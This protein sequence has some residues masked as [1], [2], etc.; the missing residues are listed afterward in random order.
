MALEG[1]TLI[2]APST[3]P[4]AGIFNLPSQFNRKDHAALWAKH[5]AE[6]EARQQREYLQGSNFSAEGWTVWKDKADK[7]CTVATRAGET[8]VLMFRK[9]T[10]QD[11]VNAIYGDVS[12]RRMIQ[13]HDGATIGG[14][15]AGD[16]GM[17]TDQALERSHI[18][19]FDGEVGLNIRFNVDSPTA[20]PD[21]T[22]VTK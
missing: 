3:E 15:A 6:V 4:N 1:I 18:R 16:T 9:R 7:I 5:G 13:E 10:I 20:K 8:Y 14:N 19:D 2:K 22:A 21:V 11:N 12:K 17:L